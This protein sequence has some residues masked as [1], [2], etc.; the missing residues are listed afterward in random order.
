MAGRTINLGVTFMDKITK[1]FEAV[2]RYSKSVLVTV[3]AIGTAVV[4]WT[5]D[6]LPVLKNLLDSI[7]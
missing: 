6:L 2:R 3:I 4:V 5:N 7:K 1:M